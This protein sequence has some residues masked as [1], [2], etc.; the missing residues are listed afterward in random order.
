MPSVGTSAAAAS[1]TTSRSGA[2]QGCASVAAIEPPSTSRA[3]YSASAGSRSPA[4]GRQT[5]SSQPASSS[6]VPNNAGGQ[7]ASCS[8]TRTRGTQRPSDDREH[9]V[10]L[11]AGDLHAVLVPL[12]ALV[13]QE[14]VEDVLPQG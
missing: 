2:S 3:S 9:A 4:Y 8:I 7:V 14:E 13:A 1:R 11:E 6:Q 10:A 5:T 12:G